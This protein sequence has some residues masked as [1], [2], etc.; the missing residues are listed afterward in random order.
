MAPPPK[1][2]IAR[3]LVDSYIKSFI[4]RKADT[5]ASSQVELFNCWKQHGID[6]EKCRPFS[7]KMISSYQEYIDFTS[8][9]RKLKLSTVVKQE[10]N[11][12]VY[13]FFKKGQYRDIKQRDY[14]FY[15]G[16]Y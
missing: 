6:S 11:T 1:Y 9:V 10:L 14:N 13:P 5:S 2:L 4:P 15:D 3:K 7:D 12:P 8:S 16:L